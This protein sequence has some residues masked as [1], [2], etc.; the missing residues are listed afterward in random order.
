VTMRPDVLVVGAG[1]TGLALAL[2]AHDNG[3]TVRV[4][5]RRPEPF[6]PPRALV[7]HARTLEVL[8]PLGVVDALLARA[9]TAPR[10]HLHLGSRTVPARLTG[11]DWTDTAYPHLAP[12]GDPARRHRPAAARTVQAG[13][14]G[15]RPAAPGRRR[16]D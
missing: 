15:R 11:F 14:A 8:R 1:S 4:V 6:R 16:R 9:D 10:A 12:A 2:C 3:A 13:R 5:D 7:V